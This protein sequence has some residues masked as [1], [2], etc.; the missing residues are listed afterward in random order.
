MDFP[1]LKALK[2]TFAGTLV[3]VREALANV[4]FQVVY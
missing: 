4:T 2:G 3:N 1:P